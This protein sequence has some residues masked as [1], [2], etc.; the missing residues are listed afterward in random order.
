[1][2]RVRRIS[3]TRRGIL[4][5]TAAALIAAVEAVLTAGWLVERTSARIYASV[6][7][8]PAREVGM[9][10]GCPVYSGS[11]FNPVLAGRLQAAA[12]LYHAGKVKTLVVSGADY[13]ERFYYE[14][15]DMKQ[16]LVALGVPEDA[17]VGDNKGLRTLDSILRMR[18]VFGCDGFI[19]ISQRNHLERALYL[20]DHHGISTIGFEAQILPPERYPDELLA[21]ALY[22][23]LSNVKAVLD[24]AIGR[25][26]KYPAER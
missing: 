9:V 20:A 16:A 24:I 8:I 12:E 13:P 26:A 6:N 10:L 11:R 17:I 18:D 7:D 2:S 1:M 23:S 25:R 22:G 14:I 15:P 5:W 19:T 3:R 4:F 21:S